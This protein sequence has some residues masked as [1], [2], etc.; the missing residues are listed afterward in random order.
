MNLRTLTIRFVFSVLALM[1]FSRYTVA[2]IC[3]GS[4]GDPVV[5]IDF[6]RGSDNFGPSLGSTT[7]YNFVT[8]RSPNGEGDYT[9]VKTTNGLN[10]G[11]YNSVFNHTPNDVNG[12]MMIVNAAYSPGIFY[13]ST[14]PI[15][16]CPNTTYEFAAWIFNLLRN[17]NGINPNITFLILS[18]NDQILGSYNTGDIQ[19]A[20]PTWRQ[21]GFQF[22]TTNASRVKIRMINNG[23]GGAGNDI[24]LDDIT[25][26]ACGPQISAGIGT[27]GDEVENICE[28]AD[29]AFELSANVSGSPTLVYQWQTNNGSGWIDVPG[30]TTTTMTA[31]FINAVPGTYNYRLTVGEPLTFGSLNCRT[32]SR[33][34]T[35]NVNRYPSPTAL[36]NGP[37]CIGDR[38]ILDVDGA[39]GT[40]QWTGPNN[41]SSTDKSPVIP[42]ATFSRSGTYTVTINSLG[43]V[44]TSS[45]NV[46]IIARPVATVANATLAICEGESAQLNALGGS[47]YTYI[48]SPSRGLSATDI[49]NPI[50]SPT[51]TT[52]YTVTASN[53]SCNSVAQVTVTVYKNPMANAGPDKKVLLGKSIGLDGSNTGDQTT[54]YWTPT[55]GLDDPSKINP[56]ASPIENTTYTLT[57]VSALGC[58][59]AIDQVFVRVFEK[60]VVPTSFSP[61][62]DGVNDFWNITAI[63]T[64][65][66]PKVSIMN[67]YGE[68]V[69]EST[70]YYEKPWNGKYKNQDVPVGVYYYVI[71][72]EDDTPPLSGSVTVIR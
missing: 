57:V 36:S 54:F 21:Y 69:F 55:T 33:I 18:E 66:K 46:G 40:Y 3:T 56:I 39:T 32:V 17:A 11:W 52:I 25:F 24:A 2:Q 10:G 34:L 62:G 29:A 70:S 44:T 61:N 50:A 48:W 31:S 35:I 5:N 30:A 4:L 41:F 72:L 1:L 28:R 45:V 53:G 43:C 27:G 47:V 51:E 23:L 20:D 14:T 8:G 67:R 38:I 60:V 26:R 68:L 12:Y 58:A 13:E 6:G 7:N 16:L 15:D 42:N 37:V 22:S 59:T 49:A 71:N 64:Y 65:A 63:E 19:N 9:I